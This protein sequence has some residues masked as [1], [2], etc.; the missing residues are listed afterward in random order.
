MV[1]ALWLKRNPVGPDGVRAVAETVRAG[2]VLRTID[3]TQTGLAASETS[4]CWWMR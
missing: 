2:T 1:K 4:R 3:L